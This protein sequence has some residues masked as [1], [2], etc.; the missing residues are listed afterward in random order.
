MSNSGEKWLAHMTPAN[1]SHA[2]TG[3]DSRRRMREWSTGRIHR[4]RVSGDDAWSS[5]VI[6]PASSRSGGPTRVS[7]RCWTMCSENSVVS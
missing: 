1:S 2:T 4:R 3:N 5:R 7:S 6:G